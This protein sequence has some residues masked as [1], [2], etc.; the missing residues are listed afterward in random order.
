MLTTTTI[1]AALRRALDEDAPWGDITGEVFVPADAQATAELRAREDGVLAGCEVFARAFTL[2]DPAIAVEVLAGD[3]ER[4]S[5]GQVL[6]TVSGPARGVL[7]A[8]R[9]ALNF[10]QRMSG[11]ATL[12][13]AF[14]DAVD[15]RTRIAD[16]RKTTPGLRAFEK[17]AVVCGGGSSHRFGLSDAVMV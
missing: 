14:V 4:F 1:D 2:T 16:T 12:T 10:T 8:E 17:H 11:I 3:G 5:A 13:R 6:A 15:G 9:I 7:R